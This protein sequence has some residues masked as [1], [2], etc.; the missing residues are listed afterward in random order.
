MKFL[1]EEKSTTESGAVYKPAKL[2]ELEKRNAEITKEK[3]PSTSLP[4]PIEKPGKKKEQKK[5]SNLE[6][7]K[8]E[9]KLM[10]EE[11]EERHRIK[12]QLRES[13][14]LGLNKTEDVGVRLGNFRYP[15]AH[16]VSSLFTHVMC[17]I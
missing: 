2:Q 7:F 17:I 15:S 5:K 4:K 3:H 8:E 1:I 6:M 9:L 11:R 13:G 12:S 10:Q 16:K 14:K